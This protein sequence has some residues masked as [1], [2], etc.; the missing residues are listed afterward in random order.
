MQARPDPNR[1]LD[2]PEES[3]VGS[4]AIIADTSEDQLPATKI[5]STLFAIACL[6]GPVLAGGFSVLPVL[7][8]IVL[9]AWA[10]R[11]GRAR[12]PGSDPGR[13]E[14]P[15][16]QAIPERHDSAAGMADC[17][18]WRELL[19]RVVPVWSTNMELARSQTEQ[20]IGDLSIRFSEM[21]RSL[22]DASE[23]LSHGASRQAID[24][25]RKAQMDLP[26]ALSALQKAKGARDQFMVRIGGL[27]SQVSE[28][29]RLADG[30]GKV[31]SQTNLLALNAAIE[32]ARSGEAGKGF[33]VV[34]DEVRQL[35]RLSAGTGS[36]IRG[37]VDAISK[38]VTGTVDEVGNLSRT[39]EV[40]LANAES[41]MGR[42]LGDLEG[43]IRSM[44]ER[45]SEL[46]DRG[47]RIAE[48]IRNVLVDLQF[49]DRTGQILSQVRADAERMA[50]AL[51]S[52]EAPD[53]DEWIRRLE[54]SYTTPEQQAAS[55]PAHAGSADASSVTFF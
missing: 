19:Q 21:L 44:E 50:Q 24:V 8:G 49:Q 38:S 2:F 33:S 36:E 43:E 11:I 51:S 5:E 9:S 34:A 13:V 6:S 32:A 25:L 31:A 23:S 53:A 14:P 40:L 47:N 1:A 52:G 30:V 48:A 27:G 16:E 46:Q 37:K 39:E 10:W 41:S 15:E 55:A 7:T 28:L 18:R 3:V 12:C 29:H 17:D 20:A 22:V 54:S 42:V 26:D 4:V 35:S 45:L